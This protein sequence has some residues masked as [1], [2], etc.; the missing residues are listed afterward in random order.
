M[1]ELARLNGQGTTLIVVTHNPRVAQR[2]HRVL[3]ITDGRIE[4]SE[5]ADARNA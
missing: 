2:A 5:A 1:N 4:E 3:H